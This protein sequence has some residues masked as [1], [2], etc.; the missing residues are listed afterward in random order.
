MR[1]H[2][3]PR[4]VTSL[5]A[6]GAL[7]SLSTPARAQVF[8]SVGNRALGM[9]G[10]FVGA[11]NDYT[12]SY[13]NPGGLG[14]AGMAGATIG[15]VRFQTGNPTA[16]PTAGPTRRESTFYSFGSGPLALS[17]GRIQS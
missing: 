4:L 14:A 8:E 9:G 16:A 10:A 2:L 6:F 5:A 17:Y 7:L 11:S 12:A 13:W 15:W 1:A 3:T